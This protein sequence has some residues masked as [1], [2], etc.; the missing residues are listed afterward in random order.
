[1]LHE[2]NAPTQALYMR[3]AAAEGDVGVCGMETDDESEVEASELPEAER[4]AWPGAGSI[5]GRVAVDA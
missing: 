3:E 4:K 2:E 1:M 5:V